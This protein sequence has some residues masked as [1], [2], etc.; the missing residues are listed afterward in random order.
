MFDDKWL[1]IP[2]KY[3]MRLS[4]I[5]HPTPMPLIKARGACNQP[6]KATAYIRNLYIS[7][8]KA[9]Y[10]DVKYKFLEFASAETPKL[11]KHTHTKQQQK[12]GNLFF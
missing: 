1:W 8:A 2:L 7:V 6:P 9:E 12:T 11:L 5:L 10:Q 3:S 4:H